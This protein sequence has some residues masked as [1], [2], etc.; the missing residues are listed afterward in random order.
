MH[1]RLLINC[2][3]RIYMWIC[4]YKHLY[5]YLC[6]IYVSYV[7]GHIECTYRYINS[8]FLLLLWARCRT[9]LGRYL[10]DCNQLDC[11]LQGHSHSLGSSGHYSCTNS[12]D[13]CENQ[14]GWVSLYRSSHT[15]AQFHPQKIYPIDNMEINVNWQTF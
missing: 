9:D 6:I 13:P 10:E 4:K 14:T 12:S 8:P 1:K 5:V 15:A 2:C 3:N 11:S 7:F